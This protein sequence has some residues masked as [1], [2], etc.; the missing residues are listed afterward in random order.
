[1][2]S[3]RRRL[4][5]L[6]LLAAGL[7]GLGVYA[8][9]PAAPAVAQQS[10]CPAVGSNFAQAGPFE[11]TVQADSEH[12]YFSPSE[13]GTQGCDQHPVIIWGNGTFTSPSFY[14]GMLEH[15]ASHG[16]IVAA[17]NTSNAGS[18]QEMLAGIDNLT[19]FNSQSGSRFYNRVDLDHIGATGH[20]QG[21]AGA[22][23]AAADP[24]VTTMFP[25]QGNGN[26]VGVDSALFLA[27][28][29]DPFSGTMLDAY[30]AATVP[31]AF[32]ELAGAGHLVPLGDGGG[33]RGTS[34]AWAR[35]HLMGDATAAA[36]FQG[37]SCG[38]CTSGD[39]S[40]YRAN[41]QLQALDPGD[42]GGGP[43]EPGEP[44]CVEA[45]NTEHRDAGRA[46]GVFVLTAVGSGDSLGLWFATT[47][48]AETSAGHWELVDAC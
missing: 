39:W 4:R 43:G 45:T 12:T 48:L 5:A 26:A 41:A 14:Q 40:D 31:A 24:R 23:R 10:G 32:A 7:L 15:W 19:T 1:M 11:V 27:G 2:R 37:D 25:I 34:T 30:N 8:F 29:T 36:Q 3:P 42:G 47:S 18:G 6:M 16:F 22:I 38:L 13:L 35:W 46:E 28:E 21:A 44:T 20:S 9:T 33:F 17:A